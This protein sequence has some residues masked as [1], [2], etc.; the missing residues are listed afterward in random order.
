MCVAGG[1]Y[2]ANAVIQPLTG[3]IWLG[4]DAFDENGQLQYVARLFSAIT[5][6][7]DMIEKSYDSL[8]RGYSDLRGFA[9]DPLQKLA[10][11]PF[12]FVQKF[13]EKTFTYLSQMAMHPDKN[14][15]LYKAQLDSDGRLVVV[16]FVL[17]YNAQAHQLLAEQKLAP[18]LHHVST[19]T[20]GGRRM[21]VMDFVDGELHVPSLNQTQFEQVNRAIML[22][23]SRNFILGDLRLPNILIDN[24]QNAMIIDFDWCGKEGEVYYPA[25]LNHVEI[26]WA[27]GVEPG[28]VMMKR[29]DL[30]MLAA[31][32]PSRGDHVL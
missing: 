1:V 4:G 29:H 8:H 24:H 2:L 7:I 9:T 3:Y 25:N 5:S 23:H 10:P 27:E 28:S 26:T 16:K 6:A 30:F 11:G 31:L 32:E 12:P 21:V 13:E 15:L 17:T 20:Y 18:H 14:R 19:E 22:L